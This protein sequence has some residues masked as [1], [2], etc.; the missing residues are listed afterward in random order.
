MPDFGEGQRGAGGPLA[1]GAPVADPSQPRLMADDDALLAGYLPGESR[2]PS[3]TSSTRTG[4]LLTEAMTSAADVAGSRRCSSPRR[5]AAAAVTGSVRPSTF[6]T[7]SGAA[8]E[9]ADAA[10]GHGDLA[11]V[12]VVAADGGVAVARSRVCSWAS[13]M[14]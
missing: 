11:L 1:V 10:D 5:I 13:V 7:G 4:W 14:P 9:Q 2:P 6:F 8:A 3:T 12:D